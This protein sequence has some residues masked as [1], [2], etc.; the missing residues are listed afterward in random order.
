MKMNPEYLQ[1]IK[2]GYVRDNLRSLTIEVLRKNKGKAH[3]YLIENCIRK[4]Y[5]TA[6]CRPSLY[7]E[8]RRMEMDGIV[9]R[10]DEIIK[11][12]MRRKIYRLL[13]TI[14]EQSPKKTLILEQLT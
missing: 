7:N 8:L 5:G 4:K 10:G 1:E 6:P 14:Q 13:C 2:K 11:K 9:E 12:K 3:P